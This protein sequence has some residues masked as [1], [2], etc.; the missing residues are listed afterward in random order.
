MSHSYEPQPF[1][2]PALAAPVAILSS[3]NASPII[4]TVASHTAKSGDAYSVTQH[5]TNSAA[6]GLGVVG[7]VTPTTIALLGTTGNGVGGATGQIQVI[8]QGGITEPDDGSNL[9]AADL[10]VPASSLAD[11][12]AS[13]FFMVKWNIVAAVGA[14]FDFSKA[15]I[16]DAYLSLADASTVYVDPTIPARHVQL[17]GSGSPPTIVRVRGTAANCAKGIPPVTGQLV[18]LYGSVSGGLLTPTLG[19]EVYDDAS[20][21]YIASMNYPTGLSLIPCAPTLTLR[22]SGTAWRGV[23][24]TGY[25]GANAGW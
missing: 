14:L 13:V 18:T 6:N 22:W 15:T 5:A 9:M 12:I 19:Y 10:N 2:V 24:S 3:T 20:G 16:A 1:S 11:K 25:V 23:G 7:A 4:L 8:S 21:A 17:A